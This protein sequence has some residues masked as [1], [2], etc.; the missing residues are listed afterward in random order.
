LPKLTQ[1]G[2][3]MGS[4][5][6]MAPEQAFGKP[7]DARAD[8]FSLGAT[9]YEL[10][11][12]EAPV[13]ADTIPAAQEIYSTHKAIPPLRSRVHSVPEKLAAVID[14]CLRFEADQRYADYD[15]LLK[16]LALAAPEPIVPATPIQRLLAYALDAAV[17]AAVTR[18]TLQTWPLAGFGAL[19][20]WVI[21]G[22]VLLDATPG[23]WL[24]RLHL[25]TTRDTEP[26]PLRGVLRFGLQHGWLIFAALTLNAIYASSGQ[27]K[28]LASFA[29][30]AVLGA[31]SV[32][33]SVAALFTRRRQALHDLISGTMVLVN[34]R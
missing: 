30:A 26:S 10:L 34:T 25:R 11:S 27:G 17:F 16:D 13:K 1:V 18:F 23:Q 24:M 19:A 8:I 6:Y 4:P 9:F 3:V 14:R 7:L 32:L 31:V 20:A 29:A 15:A 12:G 22:T 2:A 5:G 33:G 21:G 28:T